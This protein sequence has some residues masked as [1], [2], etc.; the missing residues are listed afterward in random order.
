MIMKK[1]ISVVLAVIRFVIDVL[2]FILRMVTFF[3]VKRICGTKDISLAC[4]VVVSLGYMFVIIALTK[5][6]L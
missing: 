5:I 3:C 1:T 4:A 2:T 6:L